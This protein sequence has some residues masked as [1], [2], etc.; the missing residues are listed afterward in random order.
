[1]S[2]RYVVGI[3]LG[4]TH[5]AVAFA[6]ATADGARPEVMPI[7]QLVAPAAVEARPLLPSFLYF[8]HESEGNLSVPWAEKRS[9]AVG[10]YARTRGVEAPARLISSAKSWLSHA[11]LDRRA[12]ILPLGAP[13]DVEKISPVEASWRYLEHI[14]DAW[15]ARLAGVNGWNGDKEALK[16]EGQE[17]VLT[18]PASFDASA[19]ELTVEAA[20][21]AGL[22]SVT[23]LEEPQ[24]ALYAWIDAMGNGWRK[25]VKPG[26]VILVVD[27]GG[28]TTDFSA[29]A[30]LD[31][32]GSLELARVA[33]GDH[34]LLGGDN[35]DLALA[36]VVRA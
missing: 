31:R 15:G 19:R 13:E 11:G 5:C 20:I 24:A 9:Y 23:L 22:D 7:E 33:V 6:D 8:A 14:V 17:V 28:G 4:T 27:V 36:H 1:M 16:L 35:M 25:L 30:V 26:D 10:E 34:I 32:G 21:A 29:I 3:D 2:A 18:V 12:G